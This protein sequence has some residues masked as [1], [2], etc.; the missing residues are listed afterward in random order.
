MSIELGLW[1]E[2]G[3]PHKGWM[4][5]VIE[6]LGEG[7]HQCE[8]CETARPRFVHVMTHPDYPDELRVGCQCAG[9]MAEDYSAAKQREAR[10]RSFSLRRSRWLGRAWRTSECGNHFLNVDGFNV[11]AFHRD[12][13]WV[14]RVKHRDSGYRRS[15]DPQP[16]RAAAKLAA[17]D[18][19]VGLAKDRPWR[20]AEIVLE[21]ACGPLMVEE[22]ETPEEVNC[23]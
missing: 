17:F 10:A 12:G 11:V 13:G 22:W 16:D 7:A 19:M 4:C 14:G 6:D 15:T 21:G 23:S 3:V 1:S 5:E 18:A 20:R 9:R 2:P 8:M